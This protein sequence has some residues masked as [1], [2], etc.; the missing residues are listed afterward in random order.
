MISD[1]RERVN[2]LERKLL[3]RTHAVGHKSFTHSVNIVV[4]FEFLAGQL[5]I[6]RWLHIILRHQRFVAFF[7]AIDI[8]DE[9]GN[10]SPA[11]ARWAA[12][13]LPFR[14]IGFGRM[15]FMV[16][17]GIVHLLRKVELN[18]GF[19]ETVRADQVPDLPVFQPIA[20]PFFN[21]AGYTVSVDNE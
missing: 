12:L 17:G 2:T 8:A 10:E 3:L 16:L 18:V 6:K 7:S 20:V 4:P 19:V 15:A 14:E 1:Q 9:T 5:N 11:S 13:H 21:A